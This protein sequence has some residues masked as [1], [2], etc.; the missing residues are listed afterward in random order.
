MPQEGF[1][2]KCYK[3]QPEGI[4]ERGRAFLEALARRKRARGEELPP[5][6]LKL[7]EG[8]APA[9][10]RREPPPEEAPPP[11]EDLGRDLRPTREELSASPPTPEMKRDAWN[12]ADR[13]LEE[14]ERRQTLPDLSPRERKVYRTLLALGL[15][16]LARRLG[17][18]RPLPKNLSQVSLFA[19]NDA[20]AVA[21][22]IPPASL[23][24]VLASLEAKGLIRRRAW[25]TP[26]TL[27]GR[28]GVYAAG[29]LYAVRLPHRERRPRLDLED[30]RHP[31]RDLEEDAR[32]GRTAWSLRESYTSPP[33]EDSRVLE[34]LLGFSLSPGEAENP[35]ALD[36]L[37]ALLRARPA[38]RRTL[39]EALALSLAREFRDPGSLRF[40]AWVLWNALRA[41]LYGLMEG[42]LEAVAWAIRR[43][44][45]AMAKALYGQRGERVRRPGALLAHLLAE[46]GLLA[47]F[48]QT[49]QWRVA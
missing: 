23:Y 39:V 45:E 1:E 22:G 31:W 30:L 48:R 4:S 8:A 46:R 21:L 9:P 16:V 12:L 24:R 11:L 18:G 10:E 34:L 40:Y 41:E 14:G 38:E 43:A 36:S 47:L 37:T 49:P 5:L 19:V 35:L 3:E 7:L 17:P 2:G 32:R 13:L 27:R 15:E 28:T 29:T 20:L 6:Y 25:Q 42:A 33:E 26:A 44:R